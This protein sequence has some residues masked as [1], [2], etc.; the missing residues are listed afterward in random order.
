MALCQHFAAIGIDNLDAQYAFF[1]T[2]QALE[3]V[4]AIALGI[5]ECLRQARNGQCRFKAEVGFGQ[6]GG[7]APFVLGLHA[8]NKALTR[9][10]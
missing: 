1:S 8:K 10:A 7:V 3:R 9:T 5:I 4:R 6:L 2:A